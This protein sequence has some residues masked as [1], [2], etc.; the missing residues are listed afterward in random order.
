MV[1]AQISP[2]VFTS[3]SHSPFNLPLTVDISGQTSA[4]G[5]YLPQRGRTPQTTCCCGGKKAR[6]V[7]EKSILLLLFFSH[8]ENW[9]TVF[10]TY[11]CCSVR[12]AIVDSFY[13]VEISRLKKTRKVISYGKLLMIKLEIFDFV[14]IASKGRMSN[15]CQYCNVLQ[16]SKGL[17]FVFK[18]S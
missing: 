9:E 6:Q 4:V 1:I 3:P 7:C 16:V 11:P 13:L 8:L 18:C 12:T 5:W 14:H 17:K 10:P 15:I 2:K